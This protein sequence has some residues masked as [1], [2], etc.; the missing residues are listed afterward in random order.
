M[1]VPAARR[2]AD[3]DKHSIRAIHSFFQVA[4]ERQSPCGDI[5]GHQIIKAGLID[6]DDALFQLFNLGRIFID[7]NHV[8]TEIRKTNTRNQADIAGA[9]HRNLHKNLS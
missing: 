5:L 3:G 4:G 9:N 1:T 8:V 2:C 6:W 7:A